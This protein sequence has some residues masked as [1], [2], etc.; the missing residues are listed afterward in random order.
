MQPTVTDVA[1]SVR[2]LV[3]TM[4]CAK[5]AKPVTMPFEYFAIQTGIG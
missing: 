4:N 5:T 3:T 2:L 1:W